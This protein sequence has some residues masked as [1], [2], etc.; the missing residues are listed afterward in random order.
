MPAAMARA[1]PGEGPFLYSKPMPAVSEPLLLTALSQTF[2][3]SSFRPHQR[4]IVEAI[5]AGRDVLGIM[6]TGGG[7]SL[8]YQLPARMAAV[9][10]AAAA[11][12][13]RVAPRIN[14]SSRGDL[15]RRTGSIA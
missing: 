6:P 4:E 12:R 10:A 15:R 1:G 7:K 2:G 14:S 5:L 9:K 11:V 8:C 3:Y 13:K